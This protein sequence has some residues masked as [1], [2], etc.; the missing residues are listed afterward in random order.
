MAKKEKVSFYPGKREIA[1]LL[2]KKEV[3]FWLDSYD[4]IFSDFDP[5][6]YHQKGLSEDFLDEARR[7]MR[8]MP[9]EPFVFHLLVPSKRRKLHDE[10]II[11]KR[12]RDHAKKHYTELNEE[13]KKIKQKGIV[14][15]F[16]GLMLMGLAAFVSYHKDGSVLLPILQVILEPAGWFSVWFGLDIIF[17]ERKEKK[18]DYE[19]YEKLTKAELVFESY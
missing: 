8:E 5:R 12:I 17:Y 7:A 6:P 19:L 10:A 4:D 1:Q 16:C 18:P 11:K 2:K 3:S 9:S 14:L 13:R 15:S